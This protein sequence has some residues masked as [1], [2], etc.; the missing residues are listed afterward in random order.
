MAI[1][2]WILIGLAAGWLASQILGSRSGG[3][4]NNLL[5]GLVGALVGGFMFTH[6]SS[7]LRPSFFGSLGTAIAGAA[8]VLIVW[9]AYRR[10]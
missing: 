5:L 1:F 6:L 7:A 9:G 4:P 8:L 10:A 3:L 2:L